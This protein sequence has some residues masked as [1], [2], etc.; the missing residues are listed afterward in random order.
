MSKSMQSDSKD[1]KI[2]IIEN[3]L[4]SSK[5]IIS[6]LSIVGITS[7]EH[8]RNGREAIQLIKQEVFDLV[9]TDINLPDIS[10]LHICNQLREILGN[11]EIPIIGYIAN[12]D[13]IRDDCIAA[14]MKEVLNKPASL[15]SIQLLFRELFPD[16][17][18]D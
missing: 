17:I 7:V 14:G 13:L 6:L 1:L 2:L 5:A 11:E 8:A 18:V 15:R 16:Y 9:I 12:A 10:G 3:S 4:I